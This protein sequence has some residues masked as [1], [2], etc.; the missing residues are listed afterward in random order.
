MTI[1]KVKIVN[2][3]CYKNETISL[4]SQRT[5]FVGDNDV[6]KSTILEA[7]SLV[8]TRKLNGK[9]IDYQLRTS[10]FNNDFRKDYLNQIAIPGSTVSPPEIVIE[11]YMTDGPPEYR[12]NNNSSH[13]DFIGV[14]LRIFFNPDYDKEYNCLKE[15][16]LIKDIPIEYYKVEWRDF[17]GAF[18]SNRGMKI[19]SFLIDASRKNTSGVVEDFVLRSIDEYLT[20]DEKNNISSDYRQ[21]KQSFAN[22]VNLARLSDIINQNEIIPDHQIGFTSSEINPDDWKKDI[23]VNIDNLP[24]ENLGFGT[25]NIIKV[26]LALRNQ[27]KGADIVLIDEPENNLSYVAMHKLMDYI[28]RTKADAQI[29][30]TTHSSFI[31]NRLSLNNVSLIGKRIVSFTSLE[32]ESCQFFEKLPNYD[33]LRFALSQT[34]VLV[35]GPTD[36]LIF[37]RAYMDYKGKWPIDDGVAVISVGALSFKHYCNIAKMTKNKV[38]IITDNDGDI[39]K[40]IYKK[41]EDYYGKFDNIKFFF[42]ENEKNNTLEP[43]VLEA[44]SVEGIPNKSFLEIVCEKPGSIRNIEGLNSFMQNNKVLWAMRVYEAKT[45]ISYPDHIVAAIHECN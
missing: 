32:K 1:D 44:N 5:I 26:E 9:Q 4:K 33:T 16:S 41:Y 10:L 15:K 19:S 20:P 25:Q 29:I 35:E 39:E 34:S 17:S 11:A 8:L 28:N 14:Q 22:N 21:F 27:N 40:N 12:G 38:I 2:Y 3:K 31:A 36:S 30:I 13:E 18:I 37:E 7:I 42:D 6:G 24:F 43:S 23:F 45:E